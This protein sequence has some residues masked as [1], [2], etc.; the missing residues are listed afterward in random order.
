MLDHQLPHV[1]LSLLGG[2]QVM[3]NKYTIHWR[4][5]LFF[6]GCV[7]CGILLALIPLTFD[8]ELITSSHLA[9]RPISIAG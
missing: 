1:C 8:S 7:W 4:Q 6:T 9:N 2:V 5:T 3:L